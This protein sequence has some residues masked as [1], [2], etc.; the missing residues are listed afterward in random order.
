MGIGG[1]RNIPLGGIN[2]NHNELG[3]INIQEENDFSILSCDIDVW[4]TTIDKNGNEVG[5]FP[6]Q[7]GDR[8]PR[9]DKEKRRANIYKTNDLL[10]ANSLKDVYDGV[11][12]WNDMLRDAITNVPIL[13][14]ASKLPDFKGCTEAWVDLIAAKPPRVDG[15]DNKKILE[16]SNIL[17]NSNFAQAYRSAVRGSQIMYGNKVFRVDRLAGGSVKVVDL[18][19]KCWIPFVNKNDFSTIEVN[20]FFNIFM[21]SDDR[22]KCEF[23][24]YHENG[25]IGKFTFNYDSRTGVLGELIEQTEWAEAF[26]GKGISPI[27]VFTGTTLNGGIF[28]Q[29]LL[30]D[31]D[32]AIASAIRCYEAIMILV[33]RA[34]E[35]TRVVPEGATDT[36]DAT[37]MTYI[38]QSGA[39]AYKGT[40]APTIEYKIPEVRMEAAIQAYDKALDRLSHDTYL[41]KTFFDASALSTQSSGETL[42][43]SMYRT[44]L[45]SKSFNTELSRPLKLLIYKMAVAAGLDIGLEDFDTKMFNGFV[46]NQK[47]HMEILQSRLGSQNN[48]KTMSIADA[49]AEY[50]DVPMSIAV[51]RAK[52]LS[53]IV[54]NTNKKEIE[55]TDSGGDSEVTDGISF[56]PRSNK[57]NVHK[58]RG[59]LQ[60]AYILGPENIGG[61][62]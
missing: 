3:N 17:T 41:S 55:T 46:Q 28:G 29:E 30:S 62:D 38:R 26:E 14:L 5:V 23:I 1:Y 2:N 6:F 16:L 8:F 19:V 50:D 47:E 39:I 15:K 40:D 36:N 13:A 61:N 33:E 44:E 48:V 4:E 25:S 18:P 11:F 22:C 49:I 59:K 21:D 27:V 51:E 52:E 37:G 57:K 9:P 45:K 60:E 7:T 31:W 43:A 32:A 53:G 56:T 20:I 34:K 58:R 42:K 35:I 54:D 10:Y 24:C 12:S